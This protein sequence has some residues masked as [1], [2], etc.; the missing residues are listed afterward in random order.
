MIDFAR[1]GTALVLEQFGQVIA[2]GG[3]GVLIASQLIGRQVAHHPVL[4]SAI[5]RAEISCFKNVPLVGMNTL[6]RGGQAAVG[7]SETVPKET[8]QSGARDH[9]FGS[10]TASARASHSFISCWNFGFARS[11]SR[12]GSVLKP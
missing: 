7:V 10:G 2:C 6:R 9:F 11:D 12:S 5:K 3:A 4:C 8:R 1:Y